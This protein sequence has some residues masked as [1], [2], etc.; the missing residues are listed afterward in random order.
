[1]IDNYIHNLSNGLRLGQRAAID[2]RFFSVGLIESLNTAGIL[3]LHFKSPL[4]SRVYTTVDITSESGASFELFEGATLTSGD[5]ITPFQHNR[6]SSNTAKT[7]FSKNLVISDDGTKINNRPS[8]G[9][10]DSNAGG[11]ILVLKFDTEYILRV[12][13][14]SN[15]NICEIQVTIV[16]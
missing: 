9:T 6:N 16:E 11:K 8:T 3:E 4:E 2:G 12:T 10:K 1:M 5:I 7:T 15:A 13:S 14:Q